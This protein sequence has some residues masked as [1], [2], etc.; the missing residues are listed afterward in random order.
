MQELILIKIFLFLNPFKINLEI[1]LFFS[2]I[3]SLLFN[4][5]LL[6]NKF[7]QFKSKIKI[8]SLLI[9]LFKNSLISFKLNLLKISLI[10]LI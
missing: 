7:I 10:L 9:K 2:L 6:I 4:K 5:L 1:N 3:N 8:S